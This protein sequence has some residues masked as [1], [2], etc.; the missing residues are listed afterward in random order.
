MAEIAELKA[1]TVTRI[2]RQVKKQERVSIFLDG[3]FAFGIHQDVLLDFEVGKGVQLDVPTQRKMIAADERLR[4]LGRA[5]ELLAYRNR[6]GFELRQRLR[7][8]E[9]SDP[10][11][12]GA[13]DRLAELNLIDD[14]CFAETYAEARFSHKGYGPH[15]IAMELRMRGIDRDIIDAVIAER[16][17]DGEA[18][19]ERARAFAE[20][21]LGRIRRETDPRKQRQRLYNALLRRGYD[22]EIISHVIEEFNGR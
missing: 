14:R 13:L 5:F 10:A 22:S 15:R 7:R 12:D 18:Q 19:L 17:S 2:A 20:K 8:A 9:Y 11:I 4:A 21:R 6:S 1:G 16:L 3:S